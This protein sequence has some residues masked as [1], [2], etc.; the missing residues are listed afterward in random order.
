MPA[1]T[2]I[3]GTLFSLLSI[4]VAQA[5][6][7]AR[8]ITVHAYQEKVY[9]AWIG[10]VIGAIFGW[11]FEGRVKNVAN[12]DRYLESH[13]FKTTFDYAPVDDDYFYEMVAL[14]GF[15]RFGTDMSVRQLGEVWKENQAGSWGSSL[16]ARLQMEKGIQAPE[17]GHP[18]YN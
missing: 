18:R 6:T 1:T 12:L 3:I 8:T 14:Y 15:E 5:A 4:S 10:Q 13:H 7:P 2:K 9:G 16:E 17:T 11:P